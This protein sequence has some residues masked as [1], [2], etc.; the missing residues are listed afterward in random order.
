MCVCVCERVCVEWGKGSHGVLTWNHLEYWHETLAP[1]YTPTPL[2]AYYI[3]KKV[4][5]LRIDLI[6]TFS[7]NV[8]NF[9]RHWKIVKSIFPWQDTNFPFQI[10]LLDFSYFKSS[11]AHIS[12]ESNTQ[13]LWVNRCNINTLFE[14]T[15][16][17]H[18]HGNPPKCYFWGNIFSFV[19]W[20]QN[21]FFVLMVKQMF[22]LLSCFQYF[23]LLATSAAGLLPCLTIFFIVFIK[24][25][26]L[27]A[28]LSF[29]EQQ[30]F[31]TSYVIM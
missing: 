20:K 18:I 31:V 9:V 14:P 23:H 15:W 24:F 7:S 28:D 11:F 5:T 29:S 12:Y 25:W 6:L 27:N 19:N 17:Y 3:T 13:A 21:L 22:Q 30:K 8:L 4:F 16:M 2:Y 10:F 26:N 1:V